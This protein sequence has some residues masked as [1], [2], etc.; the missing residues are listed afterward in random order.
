MAGPNQTGDKDNTEEEQELATEQD[1]TLPPTD[2]I[3]A[4]TVIADSDSDLD[5]EFKREQEH[6]KEELNAAQDAE[7][8]VMV[9]RDK[10]NIGENA[11]SNAVLDATIAATP[12]D[13]AQDIENDAHKNETQYGFGADAAAKQMN[14]ALSG[15]GE[16]KTSTTFTA[17][18]RAEAERRKREDSMANI[19]TI[20]MTAEVAAAYAA[21]EEALQ[22]MGIELTDLTDVFAEIDAQA[23]EMLESLGKE[24]DAVE[25][26]LAEL[27]QE[28]DALK[29]GESPLDSGDDPAMTTAQITLKE[30]EIANAEARLELINNTMATTRDQIQ[31]TKNKIETAQERYDHLEE[32]E[33][34]AKMTG[35]PNN[36]LAG[37]QAQMELA[38]A[39]V[40][41]AKA[42]IERLKDQAKITE[43]ISE[44]VGDLKGESTTCEATPQ[45]EIDKAAQ[46]SARTNLIKTLTAATADG[47]ID[48]TELTAITNGL[49]TAG[50]SQD[51]KNEFIN[52]FTATNGSI[53]I[54]DASAP[55][56]KKTLTGDEATAY[57]QSQW[58]AIKEEQHAAT[59]NVQDKTSDVAAAQ[60]EVNA[61]LAEVS[62]LKTSV[63]EAVETLKAEQTQSDAATASA[64][65]MANVDV[66]YDSIYD[67][68]SENY[69]VDVGIVDNILGFFD[70]SFTSGESID[71]VANDPNRI[72]KDANDKLVYVD[73][74]TQKMYTLDID[75]AGNQTMVDVSPLETLQLYQKM[76]EEKLL[77]R[78]FVKNEGGAYA[79]Y[80]KDNTFLESISKSIV[81][82]FMESDER[83]EFIEAYAKLERD[84]LQKA[85]TEAAEAKDALGA[86]Q[87][88]LKSKNNDLGAADNK[89]V[90]ARERL[91]I[92]NVKAAEF[93]AESTK[94]A[95][96][97]NA[98]PTETSPTAPVVG[99]APP[100]PEPI[101]DIA[102]AQINLEI[103]QANAALNEAADEE[104]AQTSTSETDK[105]TDT[106][107]ETSETHKLDIPDHDLADA[108]VSRNA[109]LEKVEMAVRSGG[110]LSQE[111]YDTLKDAPGMS[112]EQ[113]DD[114]MAQ[115]K[116]TL[117][118]GN[119][120]E[121]ANNT[122]N[123]PTNTMTVQHTAGIQFDY[124]PIQTPTAP[125][126]DQNGISP[127]VKYESFADSVEFTSTNDPSSTTNSYDA[128]AVKQGEDPP[129]ATSMFA[130]AQLE[131]PDGSG[132]NAPKINGLTPAQA[133]Q[134]RI[135]EENNRQAAQLAALATQGA[136]AGGGSGGGIA[137]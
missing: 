121:V 132:D 106:Q 72:L 47:N 44:L 55:G 70:E 39:D 111:D 21:I 109:A 130:Q 116:V 19:R 54:S 13:T 5:K 64:T 4:D 71:D 91:G 86:A 8:S 107:W 60:A 82:G 78:N 57:L 77:P 133:D 34:H 105:E 103:E 37:I 119:T 50:I 26:R 40:D 122:V 58:E 2:T 67:Y 102:Q 30:A 49:N 124:I 38:K 10:N 6:I 68:M 94:N 23:S 123:T 31:E 76:Y 36:N 93:A 27:N 12:G 20:A 33:R 32:Q 14:D 128:V 7:R 127:A 48:E 18:T 99:Q 136:G 61:A 96:I 63:S 87:D 129:V 84:E 92:V 53:T 81:P 46:I 35:D 89:L 45:A 1:A 11:T 83:Q 125:A 9:G 41:T 108:E 75:S 126:P 56:G 117:D 24:A 52:S 118:N 74:D 88:D 137:G 85:R 80:S 51:A 29:K 101:D 131:T 69:H 22:S 66:K 90:L 134:L 17:H 15:A 79:E 42:S 104:T 120:P 3:V 114:M 28:L 115:N 100:K 62:A 43:S 113:L 135:Q 95:A 73:P 59:E 110:T 65:A 112:A 98:S 97:A 25:T 16:G